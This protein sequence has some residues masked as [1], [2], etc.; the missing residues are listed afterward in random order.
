MDFNLS[1]D[2][3]M[4]KESVDRLVADRYQLSQRLSYMFE[5]D[6]WSRDVWQEFVE[7]G[8]TMLPFSEEAGGLG[9]GQVELM[10]VGEA[11]GRGLVV[12]PYLPSIVLER[13]QPTCSRPSWRGKRLQRWPTTRPSRS[14]MDGS[15]A[16]PVRCWEET[17]PIFS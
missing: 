7:L 4:L 16:R 17:A 10:I 3:R 13:A 14:A 5:P 1:D 2:Q 12:E 9:L 6:G 15:A 8:L 11:F